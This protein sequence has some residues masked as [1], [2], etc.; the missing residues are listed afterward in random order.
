M[1]VSGVCVCVCGGGGGGG[2]QGERNVKLKNKNTLTS[3]LIWLF[4]Q[5]VGCFQGLL[6]N[7]LS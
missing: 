5:Q 3:Q 7:D 1:F 4:F 6:S 2:V